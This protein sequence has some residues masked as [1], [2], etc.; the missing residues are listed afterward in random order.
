MGKG[1]N[2]QIVVVRDKKLGSE[3]ALKTVRHTKFLIVPFP[4]FVLFRILIG[5]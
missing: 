4:L 5:Q 2:G 1:L 3:H